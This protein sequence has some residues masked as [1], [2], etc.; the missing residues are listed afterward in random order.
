[1][2]TTTAR[3]WQQY[4]AGCEY[5]RRIG[6]YENSRR[7]ERYYR[8]D[9]WADSSTDKLP[10]PVFNVIRR[11]I[12]YLVCTTGN[13]NIR[14]RYT[15]ENLPFVKN[16]DEAAALRAALTSMTHNAAYRWESSQMDSRIFTLLRNAAISGDGVLYCY[17]DS[18]AGAP[19]DYHGDIAT[20][21]IDNVNLFVADVNR[22]DIQSQDYIILAGRDSVRAL[23]AEAEAAGQSKEEVRKIVPDEVGD[24][25]PG[26]MASFEL[27]GD[28][29]AKA[30]FLIRFHREDGFVVFEKLTR[31]SLIRKCVTKQKL[32]P[33]AYFNW[34][35]TKNSFHGTSPVTGLLPNQRFINR[36][37]AMA[38]KHMTDTA[39]SKVIYDKSRIPEWS[40]EV[41]EAI[42]AVGGTN[43]SDAVSVVGVG[44]MQDG[45]LDL[46][47]LSV[48]MT[49]EL[50]GATE[51]AL[52]EGAA[53]NTSA[54][55]ALQEAARIPLEQARRAFLQCIEDL[56]DIWADMMCAYYPNERLVPCLDGETEYSATLDFDRLR[57][58]LLRAR[59][60]VGESSRFSTSGSLSM[61]NRL[62]DAGCI[63]PKQYIERL[64]A[65]LIDDRASLLTELEERKETENV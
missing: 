9:Q 17:W 43:V 61:L 5:K 25:R 63:T 16:G 4:E 1:M 12:D 35:P 34:Y 27:E 7:N 23:R 49:R 26:D 39:F 19:A 42:A 29:E 24:A 13:E 60:D 52:G 50:C 6:L 51:S 28:D 22:P 18:E 47:K 54:I 31:Y 11:I 41:G 14:I 56:A 3:I 8:G 37:F 30:T 33:V 32:Y 57:G 65:G 44:E 40:N 36:A 48:D 10:R 20:C 46:I 53:T 55:L 21:V 58:E 2:K 59:V 64:P 45:Y 15:D 38:M 62:L